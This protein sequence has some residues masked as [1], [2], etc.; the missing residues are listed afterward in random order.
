MMCQLERL[1]EKADLCYRLADT[2]FD[3]Q[4]VKALLE[5]AAEAEKKAAGLYPTPDLSKA[6]DIWR[7]S[8]H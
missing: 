6:L 3:E 7:L 2:I 4:L 1:R 5:Y 8:N